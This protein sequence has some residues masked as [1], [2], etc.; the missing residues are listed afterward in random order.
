MGL[1]IYNTVT[2]EKEDFEPLIPGKVRMYVCGITPYGPSHIG[3]ARCY[4]SF[5]VV[6]RWLK[7]TYLVTYIRNFTDVD[8]KIIKAANATNDNARSVA[9][10]F[11]AQYGADMRELGC[12]QPNVEPR[13]TDHIPEIIELVQ[14]LIQ[15]EVAY[16]VDGDVY[17]DVSRFPPYGKFSG[18]T[19]DELEAGARVE[20]DARKRT[21]YDFALWKSAKPGEPSWDSPWGKGRPGWHIEC[22]A[23]SAKYLSDTFDIHGGGKDLVFPHHENEVAQSCAASGQPYLAKVWMHN[24]F[25]NLLP[26]K[27]TKCTAEMHAEAGVAVEKCNA[28]GYVFTE[29]ELK[30]SKSRGNFYPIREILS[31]YEGEALR[32]LMLMSHY[33]TPIQFSHTLLEDVEKRLDKNYE[34]LREIG[35]FTGE[36]TFTPGQNFSATFGFDPRA[37]FREAMDDDF[38]TAKAIADLQEVFRIANDLMHGGEKE[39]IGKMLSPADTSRLLVETQEII[40]ELGDVL[41]LWQ[42]D[43]SK[44]IERRKLAGAARLAITPAEIEAKIADR[45][46]ARKAKD[47]K[48]A[49]EIRMEL[50]AKGIVLNDT[51]KG[52]EWYAIDDQK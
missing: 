23:M 43:A 12:A 33:R 27:C 14:R 29:E 21:P 41:G 13:V 36:Q 20:V 9:E 22:S 1:R 48:R 50:K 35:R 5:D 25:V 3:H 42:E 19:L 18:R 31:R 51:P 11:I 37:R 32:Y 17:F 30:M 45:I 34:T 26:E 24:G 10:K 39:R 15:K 2:R 40:S 44:Y 16:A 52:T 46:A 49:D 28:C 8:D 38:N 7:R 47:F 6:F 4:I